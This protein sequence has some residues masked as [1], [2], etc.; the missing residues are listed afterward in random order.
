MIEALPAKWLEQRPD[1]AALERQVLAASGDVGAAQGDRYPRVS[2]SGT[3]SRVSANLSGGTVSGTTWSVGPAVSLPLFDAGRRAAVVDS[4]QARYTEARARYEQRARVAV[5]EVEEALVRLDGAARRENDARTAAA[6][7]REF[8]ESAQARWDA[9]AGSLLDL[10]EA[11]RNALLSA[12]VLVGVQRERVRGV[13]RALQGGRRRLEPVK[14]SRIAIVLVALAALAGAG[15][16]LFSTRADN[17]AEKPG[18]AAPRPAL[19]VVATTPRIEEWARTLAANGNVAPWQEALIGAEIGGHRIT[20]VLVNVGDVVKKGQVLAR[21]SSETLAADLAQAK[22]AL[23][24]TEATLA[25]ARGNAERAR[26]IEHTG[27]YSAQQIAQFLTAE[28]TA[29]ARVNAARARVLAEEVRLSHTRLLAPD[30]GVISARTAT[31]GQTPQAGQEL[32]RADPRGPPRM[33]RRGHR[34]R[35]AEHPA[36]PGRD[37]RASG[38]RGAAHRR[39]GAHGGADGRS[40]VPQCFRL[41]RPA[42]GER[43]ARRDV[44]ARRVPA[45]RGKGAHRAAGRARHARGLQLRLQDRARQAGVAGQGVDRTPRRRPHRDRSRASSPTPAWW[46]AALPS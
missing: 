19:S 27:A 14:L 31:V 9:G 1:L 40:A 43:R 23:A 24:E 38:K 20:E 46:Q 22:A 35:A 36:R 39:Q 42:Q 7:Y 4:A 34:G 37:R 11:R 12:A 13:D 28:Q 32:F 3:V 10:E 30:E 45:R 15:A 2:L 16:W 29:R 25:E 5:R 44:R 8:M 17:G 33:A 21:I 18:K 6:G 41:C 26:Q